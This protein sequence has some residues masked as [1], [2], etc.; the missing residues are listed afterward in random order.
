MVISTAVLA[1][2]VAFAGCVFATDRM[3]TKKLDGYKLIVDSTAC[4]A[5]IKCSA[6]GIPLE[7]FK[8]YTRIEHSQIYLYTKGAAVTVKRY[9]K[10]GA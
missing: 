9:C 5:Y 3:L 4:K 2:T 10:G 6:R 7:N 1:G 8:I